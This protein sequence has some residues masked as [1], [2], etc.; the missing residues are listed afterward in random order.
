MTGSVEQP[1]NPSMASTERPS[2]SIQRRTWRSFGYSG[3]LL[4]GA[5]NR[6]FVVFL[7][8]KSIHAKD[9]GCSVELQGYTIDAELFEE[10]K[11]FLIGMPDV[12]N[13]DMHFS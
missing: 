1:G 7:S 10:S 12:A 5:D 2:S 11:A 9:L 13:T 3:P 6:R 8:I 4:I